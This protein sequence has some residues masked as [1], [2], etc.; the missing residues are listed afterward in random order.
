MIRPV[1]AILIGAGNRGAAVYGEYALNHPKKLRF[2]AVAE[3]L[4]SRRTKF[5][6]KHRIR[7]DNCFESW[8]QL[9]QND[10]LAQVALVTTQDRLH[11]APTLAALEKGY[12][13]LLE[14]PMATTIEEC[15][16]IVTTAEILGRKLQI[17]HVLRYTNFFSSIYELLRSGRIGKIVNIS[18]RE[19]VSYFH[20]AHSFIRG[21]WYNR[22]TSSPMILAK[23][24][25]DLD[26]LYWFAGSKP[27]NISSFGSL[28]HFGPD[29]APEGAPDRCTNGCPEAPTCLY[30]APRIYVDIE[31]LFRVGRKGG[32]KKDKIFSGLI[33]KHP[34]LVSL[35]SKIL[36]P[37]RFSENYDGWPVSV[38]TQDSGD[39]SIEG[40]MKALREGPYG[41]CVYKIE[42]HDVVDHQVVTIDFENQCTASLTMHGHSHE[43]G[44]SI[45]VDGTK[46]AI[47]GSFLLSGDYLVIHDSLTGIKE[48]ILQTGIAQSQHGG[49]DDEL[50]SAFIDLINGTRDERVLTSGRA[51]LESHL[52][53]FAADRARLEGRVVEMS[54]VR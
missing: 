3:P 36:P 1:T 29:N 13:V 38:I 53:A 46:G 48:V 22:S 44:R 51:S 23:C 12:D 7:G 4:E 33:L 37:L 6:R 15:K 45:R 8:E 5:A 2:L 50:I 54:E 30:Y 31:P 21:N 16:K 24:C 28:T 26:I 20:Y 47:K 25:H 35:F 52:M 18:L 39:T 41:K 34:K 17:C 32:T 40:K 19:N 9:F 10:K 11:T 49:G 43:E 42:G 14:K 27:V